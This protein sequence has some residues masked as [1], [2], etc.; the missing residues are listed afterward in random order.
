MQ[1]FSYFMC[2]NFAQNKQDSLESFNFSKYIQKDYSVTFNSQFVG[3][4]VK[5]DYF[6]ALIFRLGGQGN[7]K[8]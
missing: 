5:V 3:F 2:P 7:S 8:T 6:P 4:S 1:T